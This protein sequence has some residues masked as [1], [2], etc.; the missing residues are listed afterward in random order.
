MELVVNTLEEK[1]IAI[2]VGYPGS[3]KSFIGMEVI[4]I[5]NSKGKTV[6]HFDNVEIWDEL[7]DPKEGYIVFIDDFLG[8]FNTTEADITKLIKYFNTMYACVKHAS[9]SIILSV[10]KSIYERWHERLEERSKLFDRD[11]IIDLTEEIH[12]LSVEEKKCM[13]ERHLQKNKIEIRRTKKESTESG[14]LSIDQ[15]TVNDISQKSAY[16]FPLLCFLFSKNESRMRLGVKFFEQPRDTLV[17][18]ID[19]L[20]RS[21]DVQENWMHAILS[22]CAILGA[23]DKFNPDKLESDIFTSICHSLRLPTSDGQLELNASDAVDDLKD[24]YLKEVERDTYEFIH[25]SFLE[26]SILSYGKVCP[27]LVV[28]HC[29]KDILFDLIRTHRYQ[30]RKD[31]FVLKISEKSF[32]LLVN[33]FIAE[34][35]SNQNLIPVVLFHP[36]MEDKIF[37]DMFLSRLKCVISAK[38]MPSEVIHSLLIEASRLGHLMGVETCFLSHIP[39]YVL[40]EALNQASYNNRAEV[41]VLLAGGSGVK[42]DAYFLQ[43]CSFGCEKVVSA[44]VDKKL[45]CDNDLIEEGIF[46]S[47]KADHTSISLILIK[48]YKSVVS[49]AEKFRRTMFRIISDAIEAEKGKTAREVIFKEN[50][51]FE[52][53]DLEKLVLESCYSNQMELATDLVCEYKHR[54]QSWTVNRQ[55]FVRR[56]LGGNRPCIDMVFEMKDLFNLRNFFNKDNINFI[57]TSTGS[58]SYVVEKAY[59]HFPEDVGSVCSS[60]E[61][62]PHLL[63]IGC[64]SLVSQL[65]Q[66]NA[67]VTKNIHETVRIAEKYGFVEFAVYCGFPDFEIIL[68][69]LGVDREL[70]LFHSVQGYQNR[71]R[72]IDSDLEYKFGYKSIF[73]AVNFFDTNIRQEG[74]LICIEKLYDNV[75]GKMKKDSQILK[76][77]GRILYDQFGS[78]TIDFVDGKA[79]KMTPK[80]LKE[81]SAK[82]KVLEL[83]C[84]ILLQTLHVSEIRQMIDSVEES[85]K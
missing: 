77:M 80:L 69:E 43:A 75:S 73:D 53:E 5:M 25:Q 49:D 82:M 54:C 47:A 12:H 45:I 24:E 1:G 65:F 14:C 15:F 81:S 27:D 30:E 41:V 4:R 48:V 38:G 19:G 13:L 21:K 66:A 44:M 61:L 74:Y 16:N 40:E 33:R 39:K 83:L 50:L 46:R 70:L 51:I 37:E 52:D 63:W 71:G 26:A 68:G 3:G 60:P 18:T 84:H 23:R 35:N 34:I 32:D 59:A 7:I 10:R 29:S 22:Y 57:L 67:E 62:V 64:H 56:L 17:R 31:E 85:S 55:P 76:T 28:E 6:L 2:V 9:T 8:A 20:R 11:V 36:V 42:L 72:V 79:V 78:D 58:G